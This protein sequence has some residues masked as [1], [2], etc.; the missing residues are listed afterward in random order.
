VN[1]SAEAKGLALDGSMVRR[2]FDSGVEV[3]RHQYD[4]RQGGK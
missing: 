3:G 1:W 4:C 2:R